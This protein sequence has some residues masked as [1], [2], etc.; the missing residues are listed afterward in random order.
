MYA[1]NSIYVNKHVSWSLLII[2]IPLGG[3]E[4]RAMSASSSNMRV[5]LS[6]LRAQ[7]LAGKVVIN[8]SNRSNFNNDNTVSTTSSM[9]KSAVSNSTT[10]PTNRVPS[11]PSSGDNKNNYDSRNAAV[12]AAGLRGQGSAGQSQSQS[13]NQSLDSPARRKGL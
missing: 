10:A 6:D 1:I 4:G 9:N 11:A 2:C 13:Q 7:H 3:H 8:S 12:V 5:Q